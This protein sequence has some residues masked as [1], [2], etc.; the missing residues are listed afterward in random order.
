MGVPE[1]TGFWDDGSDKDQIDTSKWHIE[2]STIQRC[3]GV[4]YQIKH[5]QSFEADS[6]MFRMVRSL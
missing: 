5:L 4:P 2:V 6:F 1:L 3:E